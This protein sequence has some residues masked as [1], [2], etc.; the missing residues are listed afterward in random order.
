MVF[1]EVVMSQNHCV[2]E[3]PILACLEIQLPEEGD[4]KSFVFSLSLLWTMFSLLDTSSHP[5]AMVDLKNLLL[6][7]Q[8]SWNLEV[9]LSDS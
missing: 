1:L 8:S 4:S 5:T 7:T 2:L 9:T 3:E 6:V